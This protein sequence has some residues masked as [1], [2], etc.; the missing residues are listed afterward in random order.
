M[1]RWGRSLQAHCHANEF[2][3]ISSQTS[4]QVWAADKRNAEGCLQPCLQN[5][6]LGWSHSLRALG[7]IWCWKL[8]N[9]TTWS[10]HLS[11]KHLSFTNTEKKWTN[12]T[13]SFLIWSTVTSWHL[14]V[15]RISG[16]KIS[17]KHEVFWILWFHTKCLFLSTFAKLKF[18]SFN[19]NNWWSQPK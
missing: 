10:M 13:V 2:V 19:Y 9:L 3:W 4:W 14:S 5:D 18:I 1:L 16:H 6:L 7:F 11:C 8:I 15:T 12:F 17:H